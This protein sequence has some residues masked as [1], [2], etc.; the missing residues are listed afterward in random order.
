MSCLPLT[1]TRSLVLLVTAE[2]AAEAYR[3]RFCRVLFWG[4]L[5]WGDGGGRVSRGDPRVASGPA[6]AMTGSGGR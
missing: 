3:Q 2:W 4:G 6:L 1:A 5:E